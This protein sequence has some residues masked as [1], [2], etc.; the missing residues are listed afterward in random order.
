MAQTPEFTFIGVVQICTLDHETEHEKEKVTPVAHIRTIELN[1]LFDGFCVLISVAMMP[2]S[3]K[4]YC[5]N[6]R[7]DIQYSR[8]VAVKTF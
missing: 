3:T 2:F 4:N 7:E 1:I 5:L 8:Q 6:A